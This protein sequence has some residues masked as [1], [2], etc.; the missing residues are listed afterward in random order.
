MTLFHILQCLLLKFYFACKLNLWNLN[1]AHETMF[2]SNILTCKL[3]ARLRKKSLASIVEHAE[4]Q[5]GWT[6]KDPINDHLTSSAWDGRVTCL[7]ERDAH[8]ETHAWSGACHLAQPPS[9][10]IIHKP[11]TDWVYRSS[12]ALFVHFFSVRDP[13]TTPPHPQ[14]RDVIFSNQN[15]QSYFTAANGISWINVQWGKITPKY[16]VAAADDFLANQQIM[17]G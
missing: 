7:R 8:N 1:F 17:G 10:C 14:I 13:T 5:L 4:W 2:Y 12:I 6:T 16:R 15:A 3:F 11:S 9:I